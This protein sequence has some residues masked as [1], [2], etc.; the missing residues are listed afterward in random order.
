MRVLTLGLLALTGCVEA[1]ASRLESTARPT[2]VEQCVAV[3][4]DQLG[5]LPLSLEL[6][7]TQVTLLEWTLADEEATSAIGFRASVPADVTFHVRAGADLFVGRGDHWLHP[8]GFAGP[9]VHGI[10][11][12]SFCRLATPPAAGSV[13]AL[14]D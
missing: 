6:G 2:V 7:T 11:G 5:Q 13:L 9:R 1:P 10:D 14:A 8:R 3:R 4:S 12:L